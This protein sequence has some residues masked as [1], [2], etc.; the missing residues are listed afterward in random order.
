MPYLPLPFEPKPPCEDGGVSKPHGGD[1]EPL[2]LELERT[3]QVEDDFDS[4]FQNLN[5]PDLLEEAAL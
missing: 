4:Y 3:V 5:Q 2:D 1:I